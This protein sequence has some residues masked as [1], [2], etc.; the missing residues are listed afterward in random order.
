MY[1]RTE[2]PIPKTLRDPHRSVRQMH[3][4]R[5][6][7]RSRRLGRLLLHLE[8]GLWT[9]VARAVAR[10]AKRLDLTLG[11]L[12]LPL[13]GLKLIGC[14]GKLPGRLGGA[15]AQRYDKGINKSQQWRSHN[16]VVVV[17]GL[18]Q[19]QERISIDI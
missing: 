2:D 10:V 16:V 1:T 6:M 15:F 5:P 8:R 9:V 12:Q 11:K 19:E 18:K 7:C 14:P 3:P 17:C 13:S 4:I